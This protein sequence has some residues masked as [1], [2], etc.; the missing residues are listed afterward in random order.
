LYRRGIVE[1]VDAGTHRVRVR[2]P[3]RQN[4]VS[5]WLDVL[6]RDAHTTKDYAL[7]SKGAQVGVM[8]DET[9]DAG[10]VLGAIY[11][12]ADKP[13]VSDDKKRRFD[14]SDGSGFIELDTTTGEF[15][16]KSP[17]LTQV[18]E[19]GQFVALANLVD[20]RFATVQA[21][22]DAHV[23]PTGVGPSGPPATP[24]GSLASVACTKLKAK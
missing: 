3:D 24:I 16:I 9:D 5:P 10:C 19:G 6:V 2:F 13:A 12:D 11:S 1:D 15:M 18:G 17:G 7:P 4:L 20:A 23:H 21:A 22:H 14:F 8:M